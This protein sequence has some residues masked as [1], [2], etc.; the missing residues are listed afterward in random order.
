MTV[1]LAN[2][3]CTKNSSLC[4][5][6]GTELQSVSECYANLLS[7]AMKIILAYLTNYLICWLVG[8][9]DKHFGQFIEGMVSSTSCSSCQFGEFLVFWSACTYNDWYQGSK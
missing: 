3:E 6:N 7:T 1:N 2:N 8:C 9:R 5:E 4:Q